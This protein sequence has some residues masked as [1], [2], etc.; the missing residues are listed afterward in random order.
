MVVDFHATWCGPCKQIAPVYER[1]ASEFTQAKFLKVDVDEC[2]DISQAYGVK[3]MP[4][5]KLIKGGK[6][7]GTMAG[8]DEGQLREKVAAHAGKKDRWASAGPAKKL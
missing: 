8:A 7:V 2:K 1:M 4:T 5:F 3:S 6:E